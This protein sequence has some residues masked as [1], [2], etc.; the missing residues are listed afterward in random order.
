MMLK[1]HLQGQRLAACPGPYISAIPA[2]E[3]PHR[4]TPEQS[5]IKDAQHLLCRNP[6]RCAEPHG[7][8]V[9]L[10]SFHTCGKLDVTSNRISA[11]AM[12]YD[13]VIFL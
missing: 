5:R 4:R 9:I 13:V 11:G 2:V 1:N 7:C 10:N 6:V 3:L 12:F 8:F